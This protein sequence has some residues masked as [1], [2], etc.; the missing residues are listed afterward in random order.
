MAY[1]LT[2]RALLGLKGADSIDFLQSVITNDMGKIAQEKAIYTAHLTT[3]GKFLYDFFVTNHNDMVLID[4]NKEELMPLARTLHGYVVNKDVEFHD[5]SD[6]YTCVATEQPIPN[7]DISF[8]DP[9]SKKLGYRNWVKEAPKGLKNVSAYHQ[10]RVQLGVIDGAFDGLKER[11]LAGEMDLEFFGG[12]SYNKG[13]YVGQELTARTKFRTEPK[14]RV[15]QITFEGQASVGDVIK[16]GN[17]DAGW[18]FSNF[19]G[20]GLAILRT[21]YLDKEMVLNN[22]P[23]T[24]KSVTEI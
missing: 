22:H 11:S 6:D 7:A 15:F 8:A 24:F 3:K 21:R 14:K 16:C 2:D 12:V 9:R 17:M 23:I 10:T 13:C 4:C 20:L 1:H 5:L 19:G 18:V